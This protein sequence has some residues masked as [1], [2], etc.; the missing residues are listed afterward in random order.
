MG[1]TNEGR[2]FRFEDIIALNS[3]PKKGRFQRALRAGGG[4][5]SVFKYRGGNNCRH[6]WVKYIYDVE[7]GELV[8]D[9]IQPGQP[10]TEPR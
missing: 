4:D 7:K 2:V 8:K 5:Y 1:A 3:A 6:R 9:R 10:S